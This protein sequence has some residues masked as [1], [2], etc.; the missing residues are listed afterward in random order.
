MLF[1]TGSIDPIAERAPTVSTID[2]D[3]LTLPQVEVF[4]V[5]FEIA[6]RDAETFF[7]PALQV[8]RPP[9]VTW[10]V[11][12]C[13]EGPLGPFCLAETQLNCRSGARTRTYLLGGVIDSAEAGATLAERWGFDVRPGEVRLLQGFDRVDASVS[14]DGRTILDVSMLDPS[15]LGPTGIHFA[16]SMHPAHTPKGLRLL[17]V[18][19]SYQIQRNERGRASIRQ[20]SAADWG[21]ERILPTNPVAATFSTADLTLAKLRFMSR[22]E[23]SAFEGTETIG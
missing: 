3:A 6:R 5:T 23:V 11:H 18:E 12:R 9:L 13:K 10:S 4:R 22:P 15:P 7:P 16:P 1:G 17:Q 2:A 14:V 20:F 19:S 8:T 21:E